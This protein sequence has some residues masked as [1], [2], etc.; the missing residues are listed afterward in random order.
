MHT[1]VVATSFGFTLTE[2]R[3]TGSTNEVSNTTFP[4]LEDVISHYADKLKGAV[5]F[6]CARMGYFHGDVN[7]AE[8]NRR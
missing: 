2:M 3:M 7:G 5:D 4:T 1:L 8:G 6:E